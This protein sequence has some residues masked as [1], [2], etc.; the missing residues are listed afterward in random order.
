M[1]LKKLL[2]FG[3]QTKDRVIFEANELVKK[4]KLHDGILVIK[5]AIDSNPTELDYYLTLSNM[6]A[7]IDVIK[8]IE[9]L[10]EA[11]KYFKDDYRILFSLGFLYEKKED[12]EI[13]ANYYSASLM[14]KK[15]F[16]KTNF[17]LAN[18][19]GKLKRYEEALEYYSKSIEINPKYYKAFLNRA[20]VQKKLSNYYDSIKDY[21]KAIE[22]D[23]NS[24]TALEN[25]GIMYSAVNEFEKSLRCFEKALYIKDNKE[26]RFYYSMTLLKMGRLKDGF[27]EYEWRTENSV[28][29]P[30]NKSAK[31]WNG[32]NL[33]GKKILVHSE[34]GLGDAFQL[35]RF[36][37]DLKELG[38][39]VIFN[40]Q[41]AL[42][43]LLT[44][45]KYLDSFY[46]D[47]KNQSFD[48]E[49]SLLSLPFALGY[50]IE[51]LKNYE[52][53]LF[54]DENI[55]KKWKIKLNSDKLK[56]GIVWRGNINHINDIARSTTLEKF[57]GLF[58][59][60]GVEIYS[61]Q[62]D[63][64]DKEK[65]ELDNRGIESLKADFNDLAGIIAN[66]DL[67]ISVDTSTVHL[68]GALG[69]ETWN[70][71]SK[72]NDWRWFVDGEKT[73]WYDSMKLFRQKDFGDWKSVFE[74]VKVSLEDKVKN[75]KE[76]PVDKMYL[77]LKYQAFESLSNN[78]FDEAERYFKVLRNNYTCDN[79]VL[80]RY[81]QILE[82]QNKIADAIN[83][84]E[85]CEETDEIIKRLAVLYDINKEY[86]KAI[87]YHKRILKVGSGEN[88]E[89]LNNLGKI[90]QKL[91]D[92]SNSE[93]YYKKAVS[94]N[95]ENVDLNNNLG[96]ALQFQNKCKEAEDYFRYALELHPNHEGILNN[97]ANNY[98]LQKQF[99]VAEMIYD[100]VLS[101]NSDNK[102]AHVNKSFIELLNQNFSEGWK[103]FEYSTNY[104]EFLKDDEDIQK[105]NGEDL[106]DKSILVLSEQ[107]L[108]DTIQFS[109]YLTVLRELGAKVF[110]V[111]QPELVSLYKNS[112]SIDNVI[113]KNSDEVLNIEVDFYISLL[114]LPNIFQTNMSNIPKPF[115]FE[116]E[117]NIDYGKMKN[118]NARLKVGVVWQG[119][120]DHGN[121]HN[122][123]IPF[124]MF[125]NLF[126]L[127]NIKF[128]VLQKDYE[129]EISDFL[130]EHNSIEVVSTSLYELSQIILELDLIITVDTMTAHLAGTLNKEVW[131]LIPFVPD[132]RWLL[133]RDDSPW[134]PTMKIFRQNESNNWTNVIEE[135][136]DKLRSKSKK[137]FEGL[138]ENI[139]AGRNLIDNGNFDEALKVF[140]NVIEN[141]QNSPD[142]YF[143]IAFVHQLKGENL[144]AVSFY[145]SAIELDP[146]NVNAYINLGCALRDIDKFIEAEKIFH[147][148]LKI[149]PANASIYNNLSILKAYFGLFHEAI[150]LCK[151][152][153][154]LNQHF[155]DA[156]IN[157]ANAY[158]AIDDYDNA[159]KAMDKAL[160]HEPN[161]V[162]AHFNRSLIL[163]KEQN[164]EEGWKEYE[165]RR[166]KNEY[167]KRNFKGTELQNITQCDGKTILIY[168]EQGYGDT[169]Q[170]C[171]YIKELKQAGARVILEC[172]NSL[173]NLMK[174]CIGV[175]EVVSRKKEN[176]YSLNYDFHLPLMTLPKF[177]G[178][179]FE[180]INPRIPFRNINH[181]GYSSLFN[182]KSLNVGIVWEGK[183]PIYNRQ[184][185]MKVEEFET[186]SGLDGL[187][188]YSLQIGEVAERDSSKMNKLD[189]IDLSSNIKDFLD[190]AKLI[191][192]M[193][194]VVTIDTSTAH[195]A[196]ALGVET[197]TM[198]STK[199]DWRWFRNLDYSP[200][201][202]NMKLF[203]QEE[204]GNWKKVIMKI[205]NSI[206]TKIQRRK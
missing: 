66:L 184:R 130:F 115:E 206:S 81:S 117:R 6:L 132:W 16:D 190:T 79:E 139:N 204:F 1:Q 142:A 93:Y 186:L 30:L 91:R 64:S 135:V 123:S 134:Y 68:S 109:R 198:L 73:I 82:K 27:R 174:H 31:L 34:Q 32:E 119:N 22:L 113:P 65:K 158:D 179:K 54:P 110:F 169:I 85:N 177:L 164:F 3:L 152:S 96:L 4:G 12:Y 49:I 18:V 170:F 203:R 175:D 180:E 63:L 107:G 97:L 17:N 103:E 126:E 191:Q 181:E 116:I 137:S 160:C 173:V 86:E 29:N 57:S 192:N 2:D 153:I 52:P 71:L 59:I 78:N 58:Q 182:D 108:G 51:E 104:P 41:K 200:W 26:T 23:P 67:V 124:K 94:F 47:N 19:F 168:D 70:L 95:K 92:F 45:S 61:L 74:E 14:Q 166:N 131:N 187:Q 128:Y 84:L 88:F 118:D 48:Y 90:Y 140:H 112:D 157:I 42:K 37:K 183:M 147:I 50:D 87:D 185:A 138:S 167:L 7:D 83:L 75:E 89:I 129:K 176:E 36:F 33:E 21:E 202:K 194:L 8:G 156:Y 120:P 161:K 60:P 46:D 101:I 125:C 150:E 111:C 99:S 106:S 77:M 144:K 201:Y 25:L 80:V 9:I 136:E 98:Y 122:R 28:G 62:Y 24:L 193:D 76:E 143:Y 178:I 53:Y 145:R 172:H 188:L 55:K 11:K 114:S 189:I 165:W 10:Q 151:K 199:A 162:E 171:A 100:H 155:V 159:I 154:S 133:G 43:E 196:G 5:E 20:A 102:E 141:G 121:D 149:D 105:W 38:G 44:N 69:I 35:I 197:W 127:Q 148:A 56:V 195:L 163:L 15:D 13:A 146:T 205:K 72:D 39:T 40:C